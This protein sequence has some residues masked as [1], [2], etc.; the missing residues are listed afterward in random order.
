MFFGQFA[1]S[2]RKHSTFSFKDI[3]SNYRKVKKR[4]KYYLANKQKENNDSNEDED[5]DLKT[6]V[7]V[8]EAVSKIAGQRRKNKH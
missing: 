3:D 7:R 2:E 6:N 1:Q 5:L 8:P 4:F